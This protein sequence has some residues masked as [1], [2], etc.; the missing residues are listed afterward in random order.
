MFIPYLLS[1]IRFLFLWAGLKILNA[2]E[3][4]K[5]R[6]S[7]QASRPPLPLQVDA[8]NDSGSMTR[9]ATPRAGSEANLT[10]DMEVGEGDDVL[11]NIP[12]SRQLLRMS[13]TSPSAESALRRTPYFQHSGVKLR[14]VSHFFLTC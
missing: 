7:M 10:V 13:S 2:E 6:S 5:R 14:R 11:N 8:S 12:H 9:H 3:E 4:L 1:L